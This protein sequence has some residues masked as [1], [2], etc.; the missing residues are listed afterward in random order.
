ML[1]LRRRSC[2]RR[3]M[4]QGDFPAVTEPLQYAY[5]PRAGWAV[6]SDLLHLHTLHSALA[7]CRVSRSV[8][9]SV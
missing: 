6:R 5:T 4:V 9:L 1:I 7:R 2:L 3:A 8:R